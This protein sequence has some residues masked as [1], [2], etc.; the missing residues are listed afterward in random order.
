MTFRRNLGAGYDTVAGSRIVAERVD[1][2]IAAR[3]EQSRRELSRDVGRWL[4]A[5][6]GT[7]A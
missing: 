7:K 6:Q 5:R 1:A 4:V 3:V 2:S